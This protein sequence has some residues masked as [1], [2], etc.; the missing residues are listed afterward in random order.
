MQLSASQAA[1]AAAGWGGD[2]F[3]IYA[4]DATGAT[5][6]ALRMAWDTPAD[7]GEFEDAYRQFAAARI[8]GSSDAQGCWQNADDAICLMPLDT[9]G[10]MIVSAP[11]VEMA[12]AL[13]G[14]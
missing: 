14:S 6:W 2:H 1:Q 3:R 5:A 13:S 9:A 7:Q 11:T 4:D 8:G 12:L 10:D